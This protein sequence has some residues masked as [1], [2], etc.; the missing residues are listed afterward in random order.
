MPDNGIG[1]NL[2]RVRA[3]LARLRRGRGG[4][5]AWCCAVAACLVGNVSPLGA[6]EEI[7]YR[8]ENQLYGIL[9]GRQVL[10][11]GASL[12]HGK[13]TFGDLDGDGDAELLLGKADG[14]ISLFDNKG[15][16][17]RPEW[18]LTRERIGALQPTGKEPGAPRAVR[19][20]KMAG[21]AAPALVDIDADGDYDLFVGSGEGQLSFFRNVGNSH[22]PSFALET[23][24][25]VSTRFGKALVPV[26][27]D[28]DGDRAPDLFIGNAQGDLYL[29]INQGDRKR[30]VFCV[31]F[32]RPDALP[33]EAPPCRPTPL[34]VSRVAPETHAAP[35]LND[36][37]GDGDLDLFIGKSDGTIAYYENLGSRFAA[38]WRLTQRRFL[39]IDSGGY[40]APAFQDVNGDAQGDLLVGSGTNLVTVFTGKDRVQV[41]DI[42]EISDN[43]L[44]V[45]RLGGNLE[46]IAIASGDLDGDGDRDLIVGD[47][48]G[49]LQSI[50]NVGTPEEPAWALADNNLL[51]DSARANA[52]P[53][54]ADL[55]GDG[56]LDLLVGDRNGRLTLIRNLGD[57][58]NPRWAI[59][60]TRF[61]GIDVGSNSIPYLIDLDGDEDLDLLVG[62]SRGLVILYRNEGTAAQPKFTLASTRF[63]QVEVPGSAAPEVFDW[64]GDGKPD[65]L[66]GGRNGRMVLNVNR[67]ETKDEIPR[68]W[69]IHSRFFERI[70]VEG[71]STPRF[72]DFNG[73]GRPD[74]MVGDA[75]GNIRLLLNGGFRKIGTAAA[76][77]AAEGEA[78]ELA[79]GEE[80]T[81]DGGA[82][83][84][85]ALGALEPIEPLPEAIPALA[86][87]ESPFAALEQRGAAEQAALE[88]PVLPEGPVAPIFRLADRAYGGWEFDGKCVP[89]FA[90]LDGDGDLDLIVGTAPG[91]LFHF[92]NDGSPQEAQW[93]QVTDA[94]A[95]YEGARNPS[96]FFADLDGD[97]KIDLLVG[98]E[99]GTVLYYR[100]GTA[101]GVLT[102]TL[103]PDIVSAGNIGRNAAP[104]VADLNGDGR[105]DL[106]VGNF[107]GR[108][109]TFY[110][111]ERL[112]TVE[113]EL[114]SR[115]FMGTDTG[116]SST[117]FV[118]ELDRDDNPDLLIGSDQGIVL[119]FKKIPLTVNNPW[120]WA[121][122]EPYLRSLKFPAGTTPRLADIDGDGDL[123]L[124]VGTE[125][126]RL[127]WYRNEAG[128]QEAVESQ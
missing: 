2:S 61:A 7:R 88:L 115:R 73:D 90:D 125:S 10:L 60:S 16:P 45:V 79:A 75:R 64:N 56:D 78:P 93:V 76:D 36:W 44:D 98:T 72:D 40:A 111:T 102:F 23:E 84:E 108:L 37:D 66:V 91:K 85:D 39:A 4:P 59:E 120:G 32:P 11:Y 123:D 70:Q 127:Y 33:E 55:D 67:S 26:F 77:G 51:P 124:F 47:R 21:R 49:R 65:L 63:G 19:P 13:L 41:L 99:D 1:E 54:L 48:T 118:G 96:P 14:H 34:L 119:N 110:R 100:G 15:T 3:C 81:A 12:E 68:R 114:S 112:G 121:E 117:P 69:E 58:R 57:P 92:R 8:W 116:I 128:L 27:H 43:Y 97:E 42:W 9:E 83:L 62:N 107:A 6:Q 89:A 113:F 126:G 35:A 29:L 28:V 31:E 53:H 94:F 105:A 25:F 109:V 52:A 122:G 20:V 74:L 50:T 106:I 103:V 95:G 71:F 18:R 87:A 104:A 30:A 38:D 24:Q 82:S 17:Q 80:R 5:F 86:E 22:L 46:R 101:G